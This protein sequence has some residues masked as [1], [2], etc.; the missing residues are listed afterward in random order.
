M[1]QQEQQLGGFAREGNQQKGVVLAVDLPQIAVQRF[2]RM[3]KDGL[4]GK[5]VEGCDQLFRNVAGLAHANDDELAV[6][7]VVALSGDDGMDGAVKPIT[8][9]AVGGVQLGDARK[10]GGCSV[11]QVHGAREARFDGELLFTCCDGGLDEVVQWE[12]V[13]GRAAEVILGRGDGR[14]WGGTAAVEWCVAED[15]DLAVVDGP[16]FNHGC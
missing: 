10:R 2:G 16:V 6:A 1:R 9:N 14:R 12:F 3:Q 4:D 8:R 11:E 13:D 15:V 7:P 5:R